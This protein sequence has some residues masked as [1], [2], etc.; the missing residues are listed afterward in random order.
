MGARGTNVEEVKA[1]AR[2]E[3]FV[4]DCKTQISVMLDRKDAWSAL[5]SEFDTFT[6]NGTPLT[7]EDVNAVFGVEGVP[8]NET[9]ILTLAQFNAAITAMQQVIDHAA[10]STRAAA[11]YRV[12]R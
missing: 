2:L 7:Q 11:L 5:K 12:R 10:V 1:M 6:T 4:R 9:P 3:G 8:P